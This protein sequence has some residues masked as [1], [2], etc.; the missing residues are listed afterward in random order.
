M[1]QLPLSAILEKNKIAS[2]GVWIILLEVYIPSPETVICIC[3]NNENIE[4][5]GR[6]WY[7]Y[8]FTIGSIKEDSR[9]ELP[10]V[11]INIFN[12]YTIQEYLEKSKGGKGTTVTVRIVHTEHLDE[13]E[14]YIE[15]TYAA[16]SI[17]TN[18]EWI[19]IDLGADIILFSRY[20]YDTYQKDWCWLKYGGIRCGVS[21]T[22]LA[23]FP[24]CP[25]TLPGCRERGNSKRYPGVVSMPGRGIYVRND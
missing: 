15:E 18:D 17:K 10:S 19:T 22:A 8:P 6:T 12:D 11:P 1:I 4:W 25:H 16:K 21:S 14:P 3:N 2:T 23:T 20:P 7:A 5:N 9:G 24:T 13:N